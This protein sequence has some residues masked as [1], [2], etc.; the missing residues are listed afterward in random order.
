M[1]AGALFAWAGNAV[2]EVGC[3]VFGKCKTLTG[4]FPC[5]RAGAVLNLS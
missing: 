3:G 5:A 2:I 4:K 1:F